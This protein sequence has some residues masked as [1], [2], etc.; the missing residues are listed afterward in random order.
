VTATTK[1]AP[2]FNTPVF[3]FLLQCEG[4]EITP[5]AVLEEGKILVLNF[6]PIVHRAEARAIGIVFKQ[7]LQKSALRRLE[8]YA[9]RENEMI[10]TGLWLDECQNWLTDFDIDAL[11]RGRA[12]RMYHVVAFQGL[13]SLENGYGGGDAG[14]SKAEALLLN[15]NNR[16][17]C[18]QTC[19][20]TREAT[21]SCL[22]STK[23]WSKANRSART[24]R[25]RG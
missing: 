16:F 6:P 23:F 17:I 21:Q 24:K 19:W 18:A 9:G 7:A 8:E 5:D 1:L 11:E 25:N 3:E 14:R 12:S 10:P 4:T 22:G 15:L 20:K 2:L 13:A